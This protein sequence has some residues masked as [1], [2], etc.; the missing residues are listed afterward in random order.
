MVDS[1]T[2]S[3]VLLYVLQGK[4]DNRLY[5]E[6]F[7]AK[8]LRQMC[9]GLHAKS[10]TAGVWLNSCSKIAAV[11]KNRTHLRQPLPHLRERQKVQ[12]R[13]LHPWVSFG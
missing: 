1:A 13:K 12:R 2:K 6:Y 11:S 3:D 7:L 4:L 10:V 5:S 8:V 9:A